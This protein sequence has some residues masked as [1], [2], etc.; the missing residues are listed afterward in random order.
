MHRTAPRAELSGPEVSTQVEI[1]YCTAS[2]RASIEHLL[3]AGLHKNPTR[4][5]SHGALGVLSMS[6]V[7][8]ATTGQRGVPDPA[9]AKPHP[10]LPNPCVFPEDADLQVRRPCRESCKITVFH[11]SLAPWSLR[12]AEIKAG[13]FRQNPHPS[14]MP[15]LAIWGVGMWSD[16]FFN[17][18]AFYFLISQLTENMF[19]LLLKTKI[20]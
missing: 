17:V 3:C 14:K 1:S 5:R 15:T 6:Q 11:C 4:R 19:V 2:L 12:A 13:P 10:K 7:P 9:G 18:Q 8:T 16:F 20:W